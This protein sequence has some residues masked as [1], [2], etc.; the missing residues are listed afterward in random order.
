MALNVKVPLVSH[1]LKFLS[2]LLC[3]PLKFILA[4]KCIVLNIV[5]WKLTGGQYYIVFF[6]F[7]DFF[8]IFLYVSQFSFCKIPNN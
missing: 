4:K 8:S 6:S 1:H 3:L 7:K 2:E 5:L